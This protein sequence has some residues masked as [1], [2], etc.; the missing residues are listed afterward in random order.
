M[1][2]PK[3]NFRVGFWS[4]QIFYLTSRHPQFTPLSQCPRRFTLPLAHHHHHHHH[5]R[6]AIPRRSSPLRHKHKWSPRAKWHRALTG[7][8]AANRFNYFAVAVSR[9]STQSSGGWDDV[10]PN[11]PVT[12]MLEGQGLSPT[13]SLKCHR[14]SRRKILVKTI[15]CLVLVNLLIENRRSFGQ[16][17]QQKSRCC[18]IAHWQLLEGDW[19]MKMS[20]NEKECVVSCCSLKRR[21][22]ANHT[23][24]AVIQSEAFIA[25]LSFD[26]MTRARTD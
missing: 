22:P 19:D 4:S 9:S 5:D 18:F 12:Q 20:I 25:S 10:D 26:L 6:C 15:S 14:R 24:R 13:S 11:L 2:T 17:S 23:S 21:C 1:T 8:T 16:S 7:I 3:W